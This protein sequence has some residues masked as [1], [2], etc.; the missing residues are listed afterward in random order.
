LQ[1]CHQIHCEV[2]PALEGAIAPSEETTRYPARRK[3]TVAAPEPVEHAEISIPERQVVA[4]FRQAKTDAEIAFE[5]CV[6]RI[7][8][9]E[10][11]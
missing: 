1:S 9:T 5:L 6:F 10:A 7:Q 2:A 3:P 11:L 8:I 4:R